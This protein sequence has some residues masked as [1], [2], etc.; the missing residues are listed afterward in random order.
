MRSPVSHSF[1]PPQKILTGAVHP[2]TLRDFWDPGSDDGGKPSQNIWSLL[3]IYEPDIGSF[4]H[5]NSLKKRAMQFQP[6]YSCPSSHK[7]PLYHLVILPWK[8]TACSAIWVFESWLGT[9][10][11]QGTSV[12]NRQNAA[13]SISWL[14]T[15]ALHH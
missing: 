2:N 10:G 3:T 14:Q 1:L 8:L 4:T 12:R 9:R 5:V 7:P 13:T 6:S 11:S 15:V